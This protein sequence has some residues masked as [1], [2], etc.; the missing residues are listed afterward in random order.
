MSHIR[1]RYSSQVKRLDDA[2]ELLD[3]ALDVER[4]AGILRALARVNRWLGGSALSKSAVAPLL[5]GLA[6][7]SL[8]D[9]GTG[10]ADV[11]VA[12]AKSS[13]RRQPHL[14]VTATDVRD[15]IVA[16]AGSRA[17]GT[18]LAVRL[19]RLEDEGDD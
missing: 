11:P 2:P 8:L 18:R 16:A 14:S 1:A 4:L 7:P 6:A 19:G 13:A 12:I 3:G 17:G 10:A 15:E 9:V 5:S